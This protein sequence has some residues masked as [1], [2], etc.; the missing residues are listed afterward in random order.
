MEINQLDRNS[1]RLAS[2]RLYEQPL[3]K[4]KQLKQQQNLPLLNKLVNLA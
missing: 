4:S 3:N 1:I 2:V